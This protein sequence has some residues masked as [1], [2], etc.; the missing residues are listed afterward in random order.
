MLEN[1][2]HFFKVVVVEHHSFDSTQEFFKFY[3]L[4]FTSVELLDD[5]VDHVDGV[6]HGQHFNQ[7][8]EV[9]ALDVAS[10]VLLD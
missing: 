6:L 5:P 8:D 9:K 4:F 10:A 1:S 7:L 2:F 3:V